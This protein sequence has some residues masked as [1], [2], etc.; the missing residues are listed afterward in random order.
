MQNK[1]CPTIYIFKNYFN[2]KNIKKLYTFHGVLCNK[3]IKIVHFVETA[4]VD[5]GM[6]TYVETGSNDPHNNG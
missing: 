1:I 4:H 2:L 5:D 6:G 3:Y